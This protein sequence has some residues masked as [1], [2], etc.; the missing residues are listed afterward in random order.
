M[1][2][3]R[4]DRQVSPSS[5]ILRT[6]GELPLSQLLT[7]YEAVGWTAY[8]RDPEGLA[9]AVANSTYVVSLWEGERLVGL[10]RLLSDDVSICY[11]QDILVHPDH[12]GRGLGRRMVEHCLARFAHVRQKVLLTDDEERQRRFYEALG[13]RRVAEMPFSLNAYAR[14]D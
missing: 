9:R 13:F 14:F 12:Q 4:D 7:L 10:S 3:T 2:D 6:G 8:T 1:V 5:P 11:L